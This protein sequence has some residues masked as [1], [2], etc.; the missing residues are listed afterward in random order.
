MKSRSS[1]ES[2]PSVH[3]AIC[4]SICLSDP[5]SASLLGCLVCVICHSKN[6]HSLLL[7]LCKMI[8]QIMKMWTSY[9]VLISRFYAHIW[10]VLNLDIF[11]FQML[12]GCL[13]HLFVFIKTLHNDWS[14]IEDVYV[15]VHYLFYTDPKWKLYI[16]FKCIYFDDKLSFGVNFFGHGIFNAL[17]MS[18]KKILDEKHKLHHFYE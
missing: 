15:F 16:V 8:V 7:K 10:G 18:L 3:P 9:S 1:S 5:P 4:L 12:K 6:F 13:F 17:S 11:P 2:T 14:H